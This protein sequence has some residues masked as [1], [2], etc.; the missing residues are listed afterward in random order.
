M[1]ADIIY[2]FFDPP[3]SLWQ[4]EQIFTKG[5]QLSFP[6]QRVLHR[7][8][9]ELVYCSSNWFLFYLFKLAQ[10]GA[11]TIS[12][13]TLQLIITLGPDWHPN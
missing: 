1:K 9:H 10:M 5:E 2:V 4:S 6:K 11:S 12:I 3:K 7:L 13:T 8:I